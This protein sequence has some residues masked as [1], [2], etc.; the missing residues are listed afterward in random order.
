[1]S[2]IIFIFGLYLSSFLKMYIKLAAYTRHLLTLLL[3]SYL[4]SEI[5]VF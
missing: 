3:V 2:L 5:V 1:M 4:V